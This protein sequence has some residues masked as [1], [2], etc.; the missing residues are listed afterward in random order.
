[1]MSSIELELLQN[2]KG[3][4]IEILDP[5]PL[6]KLAPGD[7]TEGRGQFQYMKINGV[8]FLQE[9]DTLGQE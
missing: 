5:V 3:L 4:R 6:E 7:A 8:Y 2:L 1:M 9:G